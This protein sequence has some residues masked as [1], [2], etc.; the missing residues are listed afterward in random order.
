MSIAFLA[1]VDHKS[2]EM[3]FGEMWEFLESFRISAQFLSKDT[4]NFEILC[5]HFGRVLN[6][7]TVNGTH[8]N[9]QDLGSARAPAG[10]HDF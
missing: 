5:P 1:Q 8:K 2:T 7:I 6:P 10:V 9:S 3:V 4:T